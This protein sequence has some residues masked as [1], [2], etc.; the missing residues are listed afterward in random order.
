M[1]RNHWNGR[2]NSSG[3][4]SA[5]N[6]LFRRGSRKVARSG[7]LRKH[8]G[9]VRGGNAA[10]ARMRGGRG[11]A[12]RR[13]ARSIEIAATRGERERIAAYGIARGGAWLGSDRV[14]KMIAPLIQGNLLYLRSIERGDLVSL[15]EWLNDSDV[16]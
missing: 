15:A 1:V 6:A 2:S 16:T 10:F 13:W 5:R 8:R 4:L 3:F 9:N 11:D 7:G 12:N 14:S